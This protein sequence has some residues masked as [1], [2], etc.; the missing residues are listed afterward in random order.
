MVL[1]AAALSC[2]LVCCPLRRCASPTVPVPLSSPA[3]RSG[4]MQR[5]RG[6]REAE[7]NDEAQLVTLKYSVQS[8]PCRTASCALPEL[9]CPRFG[10]PSLGKK[11]RPWFV[12][13]SVRRVCRSSV[14]YVCS[15]GAAVPPSCAPALWCV[16]G[17]HQPRGCAVTC[18][19][20]G[21]RR[22]ARRREQRKESIV[23]DAHSHKIPCLL[24]QPACSIF[25]RG[26]FAPRPPCTHA[27]AGCR[28]LHSHCCF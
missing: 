11:S 9:R 6:G 2:A 21:W 4:G 23:H 19:I 25:S 5:R 16:C 1:R 13:G 26:L 10:V 15:S 28:R 18:P 24:L 12:F 27:T 20:E 22:D 3:Q 14:S 17:C 8:L 7:M